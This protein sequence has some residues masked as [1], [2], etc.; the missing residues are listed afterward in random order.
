MTAKISRRDLLAKGLRVIL[1]APIATRFGNVED[2]VAQATSQE[3]ISEELIWLRWYAYG[4]YQEKGR[5]KYFGGLRI[6]GER[7]GDRY[8]AVNV[9][10]ID[11]AQ[12]KFTLE[13][14]IYFL[15]NPVNN[16]RKR[17]VDEGIK[18]RLTD[19]LDVAHVNYWDPKAKTWESNRYYGDGDYWTIHFTMKEREQGETCNTKEWKNGVYGPACRDGEAYSDSAGQK[20]ITGFYAQNT[21]H[22]QLLSRSKQ[23]L[24]KANL[25]YP[26]YLKIVIDRLYRRQGKLISK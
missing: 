25:E 22:Q 1:A 2:V 23:E 12:T 10:P 18:G 9:L 4:A 24:A 13:L 21:N 7:I 3:L 6:F 17:F 16:F 5:G 8:I 20:R 14:I 26:R 19:K 11:N 15:E